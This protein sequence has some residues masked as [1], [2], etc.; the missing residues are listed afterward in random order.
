VTTTLNAHQIAAN[1]ARTP[2]NAAEL[3]PG[4]QRRIIARIAAVVRRRGA[5]VILPLIPICGFIALWQVLT[6]HNVVAWLRFNRMPTPVSVVD[7]LMARISS[8]GYYEDLLASLQRILLGFG[9]ATAI[10]ITLG[11]LVGRS[12]TARMTLRPFIEMVRPI[13]AIALVPLTILLFPSTEQGIVFIT[14]F[15][16]FFP[17]VV[18]T[19]HAME[20]LPKVWEEAARTMGAG[21]LSLLVHV[22]LPGAL[23]GIF[24]GLSVAM[25]VA[26][27]C[28]VSA[29]MI[30][31]QFGIG[32]YTWQSYG[33]LDYPGVI[34]GM[35]SI[36]VLGLVTAWA[37]ERV[38]RR[39]NHWLPR[40]S[41]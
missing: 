34:V 38:G 4:A 23:P 29:E 35:I 10:G 7:G 14:F 11:I 40:A 28:V 20:A 13:P 12:Q 6:A 9:L 31:G 19:I 24:A 15:A 5:T 18:S 25:G 41:R 2:P 39:I 32:Y 17:V 16:A 33:L 1:P 3:I 27:I 21:R 22:I 26:W 37:V 36:G 30:S 8:G